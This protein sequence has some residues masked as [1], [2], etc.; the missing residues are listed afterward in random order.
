MLSAWGQ[1]SIYRGCEVHV[2]AYAIVKPVPRCTDEDSPI[3]GMIA[4]VVFI[5]EITSLFF[6]VGLSVS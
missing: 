1:Y 3:V 4:I 2:R 6:V 5:E